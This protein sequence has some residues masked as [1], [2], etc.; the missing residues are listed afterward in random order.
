M[1]EEELRSLRCKLTDFYWAVM[2]EEVK[3]R[4]VFFYRHRRRRQRQQQ[5]R[6]NCFAAAVV[7]V[8]L[9]GF[10]LLRLVLMGFFSLRVRL[11]LGLGYLALVFMVDK[12]GKEY[13]L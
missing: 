5:G 12:T 10:M 2:P 13:G 3:V 11:L 9:E 7:L 8:A 6:L 1:Q 4:I